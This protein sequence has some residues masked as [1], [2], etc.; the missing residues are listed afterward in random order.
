[1]GRFSAGPIFMSWITVIGVAIGLA[2][3]ATAVAVATSISLGKVNRRQVFRF[4]F[5]FG[6]FQAVMPIVGWLAGR[7]FYSYIRRWDH[8]IAFG[9]LAFSGFKAIYD[10]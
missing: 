3:D 1:L 9:L 10:A 5:H 6:L 7:G 8:W 2:M 4:A